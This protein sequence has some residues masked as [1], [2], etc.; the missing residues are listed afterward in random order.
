MSDLLAKNPYLGRL[1]VLI[2]RKFV[3]PLHALDR[4]KQL[5]KMMTLKI[6]NCWLSHH[7]RLTCR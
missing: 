7:T 2:I 3:E 1:A 4:C 5:S 6:P